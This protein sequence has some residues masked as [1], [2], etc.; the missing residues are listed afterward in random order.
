MNAE[1]LPV[2]AKILTGISLTQD[3]HSEDSHTESA[4]RPDL[5]PAPAPQ[6]ASDQLVHSQHH[7][8]NPGKSLRVRGQCCPVPL[9]EAVQ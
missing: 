9:S 4:G 6:G 1:D 8:V 3:G 7:R 2:W 5:S